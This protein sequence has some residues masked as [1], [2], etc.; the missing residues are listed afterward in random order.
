MVLYWSVYFP[1]VIL[2]FIFPALDRLLPSSLPS[3]PPFSQEECQELLTLL[4][5]FNRELSHYDHDSLTYIS[6]PELSAQTVSV[7]RT[8][9][10]SKV[11]VRVGKVWLAYALP[12]LIEFCLAAWRQGRLG[13]GATFQDSWRNHNGPSARTPFLRTAGDFIISFICLGLPYL[14]LE[15]S[16]HQRFDTESGVRSNAGPMLVVGAL[17]CLIVSR[18]L[19]NKGHYIDFDL[20]GRHHSECLGDIHHTT[21]HR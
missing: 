21:R 17:A 16:H 1:H 6:P 3:T 8:R 18:R 20:S 5:S 14:F 19:E 9:V 13:G 2:S 10:V 4:R 11:L 7:V 12:G 15:R